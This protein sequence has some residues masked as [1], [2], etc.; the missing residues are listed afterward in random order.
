MCTNPRA[1]YLAPRLKAYTTPSHLF[2]QSPVSHRTN[3]MVLQPLISTTLLTLLLLFLPSSACPPHIPPQ[4]LITS[5]QSCL[6]NVECLPDQYCKPSVQQFNFRFFSV[7]GGAPEAASCQPRLQEGSECSKVG[8]EEC[9]RGTYCGFSNVFNF[10]S[11]RCL[12]QAERGAHCPLSAVSPCRGDLKCEIEPVCRP[13]SFGREDEFCAYDRHCQ[14]DNG[15]YCRASTFMCSRKR[16]PG[17]PCGMEASNFECDGFCVTS[18]RF[19]EKGSGICQRAQRLGES[20]TNS[21]QCGTYKFG[22]NP[23]LPKYICNRSSAKRGVCV[24][25]TDLIPQLGAPCNPDNDTCDARRGLSCGR[26]GSLFKCMQ[27]GTSPDSSYPFCTPHSPLSRCP[28]DNRGNLRECRRALNASKQLTG[29]FMCRT[30]RQVVP[31]GNPCNHKEFAVCEPGALCMEA[32][33]VLKMTGRF[34]LPP[35]RTCMRLVPV[36]APCGDPFRFT[37]AEGSFCVNGTCQR[38]E[39]PPDLPV[40]YAPVSGRCSQLLCPPGTVCFG[41]RSIPHATKFC[42]LPARELGLG[43]PCYDSARFR[44]VRSYCLVMLHD[45]HEH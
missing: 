16:P 36:G 5:K 2:C 4:Q 12:P 19:S 6:S 20:C 45:R 9:A 30:R 7:G 28:P 22:R 32:P 41:Q 17:A 42:T 8:V 44:E 14:Q 37:C 31:L 3:K 24:L 21:V 34:A 10:T 13:F 18:P 1:L 39:S 27:L 29:M 26:V 40:K 35:L 11:S 33:G 15:I 25:E 23:N 43:Q 38:T